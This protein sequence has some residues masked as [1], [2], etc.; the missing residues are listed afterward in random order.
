MVG[1][2]DDTIAAIASPSG[3]A[4]RGVV[5]LSGPNLLT[6]LTQCFRARNRQELPRRGPPL[7]IPGELRIARF[8]LET[9]CLPGDLFLWPTAKSYT[10]QPAAEFHTIGSL[11]LL[12]EALAAIC[13]AGAR[14]AEP[15]EFT[16]RAFLAGRIDLA[17]AEAVLGVVDARDT[18]HLQRA[19]QQLAGGLSRPLASLRED[20]LNLLADLEAGL[21][22]AEE[23]I[24]F[25]PRGRVASL[26]AD[27]SRQVARIAGQLR[28]RGELGTAVRVVLIGPP[29]A[30]KS[31]LFNMMVERFAAP[32]KAEHPAIVTPIPGTT[33]DYLIARI[34]LEG[35]ICE[36]VDTAGQPATPAGAIDQAASQLAIKQ[37]EQ[38]DIVL[39]CLPVDS[40]DWPALPPATATSSHRILVI[41]KSD[42]QP[43]PARPIADATRGEASPIR[44]SCVTG[45]GCDDLAAAIRLGAAGGPAPADSAVSATA[46]R[47]RD[48]LRRAA[49]T[50]ERARQLALLESGDELV[51]AEIRGALVELGTVVG[52]VYT[53]DILDRIFGKFCIGK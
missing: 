15:G 21:D 46:L 49:A 39:V 47:C 2:L 19:L 22:F 18:S 41:T 29:N 25:V 17:Q 34:H 38:A 48:S 45:T 26:L 12:A 31:S 9:M 35:V 40:P 42:L 30:G 14:P 7:C 51:A 10:R 53:D 44:T 11:P 1:N 6:C 13:R 27:A 20:L 8:E 43:P 36:L 23:E 4:L 32:K 33:R 37:Q 52:T 28:S 24:E 16:L 3:G 50:L 5:R